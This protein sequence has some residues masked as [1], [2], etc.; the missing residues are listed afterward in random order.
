M[1]TITMD[2][3]PVV[4]AK[5]VCVGRNYAAHIEELQR[6]MPAQPVIFVKQNS[7][8][9]DVV[10][11]HPEDVIHYEGEITF[12]VRAGKLAG[13]GLGLDLTK[14]E[15]QQHLQQNGLPW[16]RAKSFDGAAVFSEFVS[17]DG[18]VTE[19]EMELSVDGEPMQRGGYELMLFKPE[20]LLQ[21]I[22]GFMALQDNDLL[23]TG[24]PKGVGPINIGD[25]IHGR[26]LQHGEALVEASWQ[27]QKQKSSVHF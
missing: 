12:L 9:S 2:G 11:F 20:F 17:F 22:S 16:E 3:Q 26:I 18:E 15:L 13:V 14:R 7:S 27:V 1:N 23:M 24:T 25:T 10:R 5:I 4:P 19:L 6:P 8:I 21:E